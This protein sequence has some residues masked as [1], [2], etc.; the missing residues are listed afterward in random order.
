MPVSEERA[1][2][3]M[4]ELRLEYATGEL[5]EEGVRQITE[6]GMLSMIATLDQ[7]QVHELEMASALDLLD[8]S[9]LQSLK[10]KHPLYNF[11][12]ER[13]REL[14]LSKIRDAK[15]SGKMSSPPDGT[16]GRVGRD[17]FEAWLSRMEGVVYDTYPIGR[18]L[19]TMN[20]EY[21]LSNTSIFL[22]RVDH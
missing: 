11:E 21:G 15:A 12:P 4:H 2:I 10:E 9:A 22:Q 7:N 6:E 13:C 16:G 3:A 20:D 14:F 8:S 5:P 18:F 1:Y 19:N 17:E